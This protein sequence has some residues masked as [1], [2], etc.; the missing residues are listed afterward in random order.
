MRGI[1]VTKE[2]VDYLNNQGYMSPD[3]G[4]TLFATFI[5]CDSE[6]CIESC[7]VSF[8]IPSR[9]FDQDLVE[10]LKKEKEYR[11]SDEKYKKHL[12]YVNWVALRH[13]YAGLA[14]QALI[15]HKGTCSAEDARVFADDLIKELQEHQL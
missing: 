10:E 2:I 12:E 11:E 8:M 13:R 5:T 9:F 1:V 7:N 15:L 3:V 6:V 4:E 14:M